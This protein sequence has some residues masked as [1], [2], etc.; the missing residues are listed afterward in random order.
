MKNKTLTIRK[1]AAFLFLLIA[2]T[3]FAQ[4][5]KPVQPMSGTIVK[6]T[7]KPV[8]N[9]VSETPSNTIKQQDS[10]HAPYTG[11][12]PQIPHT[13]VF[14][15]NGVKVLR[16]YNGKGMV[17]N[18]QYTTLPCN[19]TT[20]P[21]D[22][23]EGD[24]S[25]QDG[26]GSPGRSNH[27]NGDLKEL[28][29]IP[30]DQMMIPISQ[31]IQEIVDKI[32]KSTKLNPS[33]ITDQNQTFLKLVKQEKDTYVSTFSPIDAEGPI[34]VI[35]NYHYSCAGNCQKGCDINN[36]KCA[37][38]SLPNYGGQCYAVITGDYKFYREIPVYNIGSIKL[39]DNSGSSGNPKYGELKK[40]LLAYDFN[41]INAEVIKEGDDSVIAV[42]VSSGKYPM[43]LFNK[44]QNGTTSE[45]W[46][47]YYSSDLPN[48]TASIKT[49]LN[50][51]KAESS[52]R[53][54]DYVG[55]VTLLR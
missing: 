50:M 38:C 22:G 41:L 1:W 7:K 15:I 14:C 32:N 44:I 39:D 8:G 23:I 12:I 31:G 9:G 54:K 21:I 46:I 19:S 13:R 30:K 47:A 36:G 24:L 27:W 52:S 5:T 16:Y 40:A 3:V 28:L 49:F 2:F 53:K 17:I 26:S 6:G 48:N 51:K 37:P 10:P 20:W 11:G 34:A 33:I 18:S 55:H 25:I 4:E 43:L 45:D 42:L 29:A 35:K